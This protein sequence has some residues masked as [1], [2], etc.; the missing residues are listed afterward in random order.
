MKRRTFLIFTLILGCSKLF[1]GNKAKQSRL[2]YINSILNHMFP[3][4][5]EFN[6]FDKINGIKFFIYV[7]KHPTFN[8]DDLNFLMDGVDRFIFDHPDFIQLSNTGKEKALREFEN[9]TYG[10]NWLS[11]L[12]YYGLEAMLGDPIYGGNKNFSGWKNFNHTIP[13]PTAHKPFGEI[14]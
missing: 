13:K 5:A 14:S 11:T 7:I 10:Q 12:L 3:T 2:E 9:T 4:T 1:A 6:G 8:K